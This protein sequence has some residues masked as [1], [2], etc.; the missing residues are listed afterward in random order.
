MSDNNDSDDNLSKAI[1]Y[2]IKRINCAGFPRLH[3]LEK[4][5]LANIKN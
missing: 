5:V 1:Y 4:L 2:L 3:W